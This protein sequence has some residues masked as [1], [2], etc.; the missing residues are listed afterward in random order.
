MDV[1]M[2]GERKKGRQRER[3]TYRQRE[4][5]KGGKMRVTEIRGQIGR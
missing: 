1:W 5:E 3:Q 2:D 4:R